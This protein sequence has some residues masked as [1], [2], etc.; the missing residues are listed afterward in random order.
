LLFFPDFQVMSVVPDIPAGFLPLNWATV[1]APTFK[2][3]V[4][5]SPFVL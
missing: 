2:E 5:K 1:V 3:R 4:L